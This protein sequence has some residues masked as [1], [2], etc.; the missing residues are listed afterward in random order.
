MIRAWLDGR[1]L[2]VAALLLILLSLMPPDGALSDNEEDYFALAAHSVASQVPPNSAVF[3]ASRHR[4]A[5]EFLLGHLI[6]V[7]GFAGAQI[8]TRLLAAAAY[9]FLLCALFRRFALSA[10]DAV[11]VILVFALLGQ[12]LVGGEWLFNGFEAKVVAYG[13]VLAGLCA[14]LS[15]RSLA[16]AALPFAAATYFHFLVGGFWFVAAMGLRLIEDR[17]DWRAIALATGLFSVLVA[18]L[19]TLITRS[20]LGDSFVPPP[21]VRAPD[22]IYAII[23]APWHAAPFLDRASFVTQWLPG[24][25]LAGAMLSGAVAIARTTKDA[26]LKPLAWWL[27]ALLAYLVLALIPSYFDRHTGAL[28]KFYLFRPA[29]LTLLLWLAFAVAYLGRLRLWG[30]TAIKLAALALLAPLFLSAAERRIA[31]DVNGRLALV[32]EKRAIADVL[33]RE[34]APDGV[35]L[36]DPEIEWAALDFERRTG[37]PTLVM[38]KFMPTNDREIVEWYRRMEFRR[39]VF[40]GGCSGETAYPVDFLLTTP[41]RAAAL[42]ATCGP[43]VYAGARFALLRR[44]P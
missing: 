36:V 23:R 10:L 33:R 44:S 37:H 12:T 9:A 42:S 27:A 8:M 26:Q 19:A 5:S 39:R 7:V 13:F 22:V 43:I 14:A 16:L 40:D 1:K 30:L 34:P 15:R 6:A 18:P 24:Y 41:D 3:D 31:G 11:L 29:A 21:D 4:A 2:Y 25:L 20:R 38:W 17:R 35:V 32:P 28:G